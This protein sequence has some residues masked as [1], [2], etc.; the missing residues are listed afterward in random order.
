MCHKRLPIRRALWLSYV[1][2]L[3]IAA[4][5]QSFVPM[6]KVPVGIGGFVDYNCA[7]HVLEH[8]IGFSRY[9]LFR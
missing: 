4:V 6:V 2:V 1:A 5:L 9:S 7:G 8:C 3:F